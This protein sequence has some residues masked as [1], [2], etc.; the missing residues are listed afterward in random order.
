[1]SEMPSAGRTSGSLSEPMATP[2]PS[3]GQLILNEVFINLFADG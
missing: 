1:M 3:F 2:A